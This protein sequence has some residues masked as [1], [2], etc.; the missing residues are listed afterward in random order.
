M[1]NGELILYTAE[2]GKV[3]IQLR[4]EGETVWLTQL[5]MTE[6]FQTN[7]SFRFIFSIIT[8][9]GLCF[10]QAKLYHCL[11]RKRKS[12]HVFLIRWEKFSISITIYSYF[13]KENFLVSSDTL[14]QFPN[15]T[16]P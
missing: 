5:E 3:S 16:I 15:R 14:S 4:A 10:W 11:S 9:I 8:P 13:H 1:G 6:L 12:H 2:D 7:L